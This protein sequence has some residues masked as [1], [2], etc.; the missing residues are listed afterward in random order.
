MKEQN[1]MIGYIGTYTKGTS[2]GIYSFRLNTLTQTISEP[3]LVA[4]LTDPTYLAISKDQKHLFS[5]YKANGKGAIA[6]YTIDQNTGQLS[7]NKKSISEN[8]SYCYLSINNDTTALVA[9][10]YGDGMVESF[11]I[12]DD[13]SIGSAV[14]TIKHEGSGPNLERQENAHTHYAQFTPDQKFIAVVDLGMDQILTY[15]LDQEHHLHKVHTLAVLPGSGPRH[16]VFHPNQRFAYVIA[17]LLPEVIVLQYQKDEGSFKAIQTIR[18]VPEDFISNNQGSAIHISKDGCFVYAANRG[19]DSIA[20]FAVNQ[21][22]GKLSLVQVI[23]TEG[24]WPRDFSL[25]P[26]EDFLVA[27]NEESGCLSLYARNHES[28]MLTLLQANIQVPFPV[29]VKFLKCK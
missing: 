9:A 18:S 11:S 26:T 25:D 7:L 4:E 28:G 10:S 13:Q 3:A 1:I 6:S 24:N 21:D 29:C 17:E 15:R 16:L 23:G 8:G 14:S 2:Q 22:T 20:V 19:H 27:S 12:L 5:I